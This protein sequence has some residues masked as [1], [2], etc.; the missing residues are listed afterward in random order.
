MNRFWI[1]TTI[2]IL[3]SFCQVAMAD[4]MALKLE[5]DPESFFEAPDDPTFDAD[6][7]DLTL[8]AWVNP[9]DNV[10]ERM[11][12]NKEDVYEIAI[13]DGIFKTAIMTVDKSWAWIDSSEEA[14]VPAN[15]WTHVAITYDREKTSLYVHGKLLAEN[16][17]WKGK[18]KDS[19]DTFKVGRRT[20]GGDT[21]SIYS[22]LIDE[23]RIS[24]VVR[25]TG[26]FDVPT[27]YFRPDDDT[28]ALY[29]F[30]EAHETVVEDASPNGNHGNLVNAA[31][32]VPADTPIAPCTAVQAAGKLAM[33]WGKMKSE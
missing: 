17:E 23:V 2:A 27:Q 4:N 33:T 13:V 32:L 28:V 29:H 19:P 22:G 16:D 21:H 3:F 25:Y 14:N 5:G 1:I 11:I 10:G 8:E 15:A 9:A 18:L 26:D 20:R 31:V 24:S 6:L 12:L 30:D 7:E